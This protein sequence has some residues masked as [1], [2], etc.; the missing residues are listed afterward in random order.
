MTDIESL[1]NQA[2]MALHDD[3]YKNYRVQL[4]PVTALAVRALLKVE[5]TDAEVYRREVPLEEDLMVML[6]DRFRDAISFSAEDRASSIEVDINYRELNAIGDVI[7]TT[8]LKMGVYFLNLNRAFVAAGGKD[9]K[10]LKFYFENL[11]EK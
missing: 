10:R 4:D 7:S 1:I 8:R 2:E 5:K 9:N 3:S 11:L 6:S